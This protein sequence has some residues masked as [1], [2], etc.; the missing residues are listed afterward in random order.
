MCIRDRFKAHKKSLELIMPLDFT[1]ALTLLATIKGSAHVLFFAFFA[2]TYGSLQF[3][4]SSTGCS[5]PPSRLDEDPTDTQHVWWAQTT[6]LPLRRRR[7]RARRTPPRR[8]LDG[9]ER[10]QG[11]IRASRFDPKKGGLSKGIRREKAKNAKFLTHHRVSGRF[12]PVT[13]G[14]RSVETGVWS[15]F[16]AP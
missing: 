10:T 8:L 3:V 9:L 4:A 5:R 15:G 13:G 2:M 6:W 11:A 16:T 12:P 7:T 1:K 14:A